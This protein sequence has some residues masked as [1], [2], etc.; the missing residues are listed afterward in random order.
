MFHVQVLDR[1]VKIDVLEEKTENL[2]SQVGYAFII[3]T[4]DTSSKTSSIFFFGKLKEE[5]IN[6]KILHLYLRLIMPYAV[7]TT[8]VLIRNFSPQLTQNL[9]SLVLCGH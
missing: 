4:F 3:F 9:D 5:M 7:K 1:G 8:V 2:R 6:E